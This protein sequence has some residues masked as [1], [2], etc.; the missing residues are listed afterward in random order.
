ML[1]SHP[2]SR[3]QLVSMPYCIAINQEA[4]CHFS[5]KLGVEMK[6]TSYWGR[7]NTQVH[8]KLNMK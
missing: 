2:S 4:I 8:T 3:Q 6:V 5:K 1:S 7:G